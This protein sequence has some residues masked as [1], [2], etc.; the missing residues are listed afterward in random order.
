MNE[1]KESN[2]DKEIQVFLILIGTILTFFG[3]LLAFPRVT[4]NLF[5][6]NVDDSELLNFI[7]FPLILIGFPLFLFGIAYPYLEAWRKKK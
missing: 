2:T 4:F 7:G 1:T 5:L 6:I 3:F